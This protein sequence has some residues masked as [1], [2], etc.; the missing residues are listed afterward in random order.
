MNRTTAACRQR[1]ARL[2]TVDV[3]SSGMQR[4]DACCAGLVLAERVSPPIGSAAGLLWSRG[5][6]ND[7]AV[8]KLGSG[9]G[10]EASGQ[11]FLEQHFLAEDSS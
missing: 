10:T 4:P 5:S 9:E 2:G 7:L 11:C 6:G 1:R 3:G 8:G